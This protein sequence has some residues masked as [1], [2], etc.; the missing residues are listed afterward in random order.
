MTSKVISNEVEKCMWLPSELAM[1]L[2]LPDLMIQN[3]WGD[4]FRRLD[5]LNIEPLGITPVRI[6]PQRLARLYEN[7][8]LNAAKEKRL[9]GTWVTPAL[10]EMDMSIALIVACKGASDLSAFLDKM[11]GASPWWQRTPE[12]LRAASP[13]SHRGMSLF[14]TPTDQEDFERTAPLFFS[15]DVLSRIR[16]EGVDRHLEWGDICE[17]RGYLPPAKVNHPLS[18]I[19][20]V[21]LRCL[22][23]LAVDIHIQPNPSYRMLIKSVNDLERLINE[24]TATQM[25]VI[26]EEGLNDIA[27]RLSKADSP[28]LK[29]LPLKTNQLHWFSHGLL[30]QDRHALFNLLNLL[31]R[32]ETYSAVFFDYTREV[33]NRNNLS[34]SAMEKHQLTTSIIFY[35]QMY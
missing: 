26:F 23:L 14:H 5:N 25:K 27:M 33:L 15:P 3:V 10:I 7:H 16:K 21:I 12:Q 28:T 22:T 4:L 2:L 8:R 32:P 9:D 24:E 11:K 1:I 17:L 35:P 30:D 34:L 31:V 20:R 29:P 6:T 19:L 18:I 13:I